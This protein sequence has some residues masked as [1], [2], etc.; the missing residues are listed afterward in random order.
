R[1]PLPFYELWRVGEREVEAVSGA[2]QPS[3][4]VLV[5]GQA[6]QRVRARIHRV[7]MRTLEGDG[8]ED[9]T[10]PY[11]IALY[12]VDPDEVK[13]KLG[14]HRLAEHSRR[15]AAHGGGERRDETGPAALRPPQISTTR[16][17][18]RVGGLPFRDVVELGLASRDLIPQ[19]ARMPAGRRAV[20]G[21]RDARQLDVAEPGRRGSLEIVPVHAVVALQLRVRYRSERVRYLLRVDG[22]Q[23][24]R[25]RFV[26]VTPG[27]PQL[28]VGNVEVGRQ[29][30]LQLALRQ[31]LA[32]QLFDLRRELRTGARDVALPLG[33]VELTVGLESGVLEHLLHDLGRR[34]GARGLDDLVV[35]DRDTEA[36]VRPVEQDLLDEL[37]GN[38]ILQ[39]PLV[40]P[41]QPPAALLPPV[42]VE[43]R[44]VLLLERL[45]AHDGAVHLEDDVS[46]AAENLLD[47]SV[48]HPAD[49]AHRH[50]P[51]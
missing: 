6:V 27:A 4:V 9:V 46:A 31:V 40:L 38:P 49:E 16:T 42:L 15:Q 39:L 5:R 3:A 48:R 28:R 35:R 10:H 14:A 41:R 44:L 50:H 17:R 18:S 13:P 21:A 32:V 7:Q 24:N 45:G 26:L 36:A 23:R 8:N 47:L 11:R 22:E 25:H 1:Q 12:G 19:G 37:V 29:V 30:L 43:H 2:V 34:R 20:G 51:Q 33:D